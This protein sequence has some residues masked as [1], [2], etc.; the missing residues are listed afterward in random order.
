MSAPTVTVKLQGGPGNLLFQYAAA[1]TLAGDER[2]IVVDGHP[3]RVKTLRQITGTDVPVARALSSGRTQPGHRIQ[4]GARRALGLIRTVN[5]SAVQAFDPPG[6]EW[7]AAHDSERNVELHG[8]FQHPEFVLPSIEKVA[9]TVIR[10]IG[11]PDRR[12]GV[13]GVNIR[14]GDY[15]TLGHA[16]PIDFYLRAA[17]VFDSDA[18]FEVVGDDEWACVGLAHRLEQEGLRA[19]ATASPPDCKAINDLRHL[20]GCQHLI[21]ANSSFSWWAAV[22][23][24]FEASADVGIVV[25]PDP[26]MNH[27]GAPWMFDWV[28]VAAHR[29]RT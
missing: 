6:P 4:H 24:R 23:R 12:S 11:V 22:L 3:E 9:A 21:I 16:L 14:R 7:A 1:L 27:G 19:S 25:A 17:R 20:A 5:Q 26:W 8:Y 15:V 28:K 10:A 29:P 18:S 13:V 2:T